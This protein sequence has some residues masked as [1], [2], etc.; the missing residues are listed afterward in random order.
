[1]IYFYIAVVILLV[2][3]IGCVMFFKKKK[4]K[5]ESCAELHPISIQEVNNI[6][7][8]N[9]PQGSMIDIPVEMLPAEI[10]LDTSKMMEITDQTVL[11]RIDS[12]IPEL[13]QMSAA[14]AGSIAAKAVKEANEAA[15]DIGTVYRAIIPSGTRLSNSQSMENAVRGFYRDAN[16]ISGHANFVEVNPMVPQSSNAAVAVDKAAVVSAAT[17]IM[18]VSSLV[19]GQY[20]M[21]QINSQLAD[22]NDG[23][24]EISEFQENEYKSRIIALVSQVKNMASF[25][26]EVMENEDVRENTLTHL[27]ILENECVQ[28]LGQANL[29]IRDFSTKR[30]LKYADYEKDLLKA[31]NWFTFQQ[32]LLQVLYRIADLK[33]VFYMGK[34]SRAYCERELSD[35]TEQ[36]CQSQKILAVWNESN[37]K[38]FGIDVAQSKRKRQ[39]LDGLIHKIPGKFREELNFRQIDENTAKAIGIQITQQT[40]SCCSR[41][42]LYDEDVQIISKDGKLYYLPLSEKN[43]QHT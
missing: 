38:R 10:P 26:V 18:G 15:K 23:L 5:E 22:I 11:A 4:I 2:T 29:T 14:A 3:I 31:Q 7:I 39:G 34:V 32:T 20:Y 16:N 28:L 37:V 42:E 19:V 36:V 27:D 30:E 41:R 43:V 21:T 35:Y 25:Q 12:L 1:M 8:P 13:A 6:T 40:G 9:Q 17:A 33:Y 24:R